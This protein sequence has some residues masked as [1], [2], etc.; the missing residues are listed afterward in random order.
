MFVK[1][2]SSLLMYSK[3]MGQELTKFH[4]DNYADSVLDKKKIL[5]WWK[6][7]KQLT[8]ITGAL[9]LMSLCFS[10]YGTPR[11]S[12]KEVFSCVLYLC[13]FARYNKLIERVS[14]ECLKTKTKVI[15]LANQKGLR[16]SGKPIKT[17]SNYT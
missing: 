17:W 12:L 11:I 4:Q 9:I 7:N 15:T 13:N 8:L 1:W 2:F 16:Q 6:K 3:H 10:Q 5:P 14:I